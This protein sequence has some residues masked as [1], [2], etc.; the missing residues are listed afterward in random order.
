MKLLSIILLLESEGLE[1]PTSEDFVKK[2]IPNFWAFLVQF[3]AFIFM[4]LIVIKFAYKP[5]AKFI[6]ARK[7]YVESNLEEARSKNEEAS[8][9]LE[10]TKANLQSSQKEAIQIIQDAKKEASKEREQILEDTKREIAIKHAKAQEDI[11]IEQ[12]KAIKE[13]HDDVVD[14]ALEATK[15]ILG[16]EVSDKDDKALLDSFV[17]DL[18]EEKVEK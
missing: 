6:K 9:N 11:K 10:E 18:I 12:E 16:R 17:N 2:F 14:I 15:N 1:I 8:K 7:E 5:I 13:M 3:I 4:V